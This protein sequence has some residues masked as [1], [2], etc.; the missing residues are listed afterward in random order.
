MGNSQSD[1]SNSPKY[2]NNG[3]GSDINILERRLKQVC[4][5]F[6]HCLGLAGRHNFSFVLNRPTVWHA[7][8]KFILF[9]VILFFK[10]IDFFCRV[11]NLILMIL[12]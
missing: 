8:L 5:H 3:T 6:A 11:Y 9:T 1:S 2:N 10:Q 4:H 7:E 12:F